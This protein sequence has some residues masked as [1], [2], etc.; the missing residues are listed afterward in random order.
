MCKKIKKYL[1]KH[2]KKIA[3]WSAIVGTSAIVKAGD[4]VTTD[5]GGVTVFNTD[6]ITVPL[7]G[8][9]KS[10]LNAG[11]GIFILVLGAYILIRWATK[12]IGRGVGGRA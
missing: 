7:M 2:S 12:F 5:A 3:V 1:S 8:F 11:I 4:F 9:F 10:G 6:E